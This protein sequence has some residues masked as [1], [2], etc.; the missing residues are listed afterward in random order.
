MGKR[1]AFISSGYLEEYSHRCKINWFDAFNKLKTV[2]ELAIQN[3]EYYIIASSLFSSKIEGN[4]L[5]MNSFMR[6]RGERSFRK[7]KEVKEIEDLMKAY[8]FANQNKITI[9]NFLEAH[10]I[11]SQTLVD[12]K[13]RGKFRKHQ[14]GVYDSSTGRPV[15]IA[16]EPENVSREIKKLFEDISTLISRDLSYKEVFYYA[17]MIHLWTAKIH[18]FADGNGRTARLL[19]KWFLAVKFGSAAWSVNS[20][21]YYWDHRPEYYKNISLG[22]NYYALSWGRCISF[23]LMLPEALSISLNHD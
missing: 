15:Y 20:E 13:N 16:V 23:L 8:K 9:T 11:L 6:N 3:F 4:T 21:K 17:S 5:D 10:R 1:L 14:V 19:E 18:P 12:A 22:F 7:H 2:K